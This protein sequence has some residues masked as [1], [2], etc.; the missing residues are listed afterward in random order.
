MDE[1]D[2]IA[3]ARKGDQMAFAMLFQ[4]NYS[5]L[6]K[7]LI[8][9]TF[10]PDTAEDLAQETMAKSIEKLASY[11]GKSKFLTWL[12]TI[13][14][15][16]YIDQTR[17]KKREQNWK[18]SE[19]HLRKMKWSFESRNEDWNDCIE[20]LGKLSDEIRVPIILKHYY[21]YSYEEIS[22]IMGIAEGTVKSRIHNG[23]NTVRKELKLDE[24]GKNRTTSFT[25]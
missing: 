9:I 14:T 18:I 11:N 4:Q 21:G 16:L 8:K 25:I 19:Q 24:K 3:N 22:T 7:Y 10:S 2:L 1:K 5:I 6:V 17:K 12:I 20:A 23:I 13:A 15:N